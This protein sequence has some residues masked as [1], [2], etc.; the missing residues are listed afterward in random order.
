[1][2]YLEFKTEQRD[3]DGARLED[4][5]I[6]PSEFRLTVQRGVPGSRVTLTLGVGAETHETSVLCDRAG[7]GSVQELVASRAIIDAMR[8][9]G[10]LAGEHADL[11]TTVNTRRE[12]S[13]Q[14]AVTR[15]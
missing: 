11:G 6:G 3:P 1:M 7:A 8:R 12:L 14:I 15:Q 5:D 4:A 10:A 13:M 2:P 9:I